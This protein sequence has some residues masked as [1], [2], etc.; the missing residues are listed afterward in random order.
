MTTRNVGHKGR[1]CPQL[2][3]TQPGRGREGQSKHQYSGLKT[4]TAG[5]P[6]PP[7]R[8]HIR[9]DYQNQC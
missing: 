1:E 3:V 6:L 7:S 9:A 5:N 4:Q 2:K 8:F